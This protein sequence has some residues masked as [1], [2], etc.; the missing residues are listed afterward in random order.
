[1]KK[2]ALDA[3]MIRH[4]GIGTYVRGLLSGMDQTGLPAEMKI[5]LRCPENPGYARFDWS[6]FQS[7]IYSVQEQLA[8]TS[9]AG[10][11][12]LWH[13]PHYNI[14][15][16]LS[17]PKL[18]VTVHDL[19]HWIFRG[20]F[21]SRMQAYY[22]EIMMRRLVK[23]SARVIA[24]SQKT[25]QDLIDFFQAPADKITVI[26]EGVDPAF[27]P[28]ETPVLL[29]EIRVKHR[30]PEKF[31]LYVGLLKPHK[32]VLW[33]ARLFRRLHCEKKISA[34]LV[35]VGKKDRA[36]RPGFEE[37]GALSREDAV[38]YLEQTTGD[39]LKKL[40]QGAL[41]LVH[42]SLYEGFGLTL[43]ESMAS[44]TPVIA[45]NTASIPE[46]AGDAGILLRPND[47]DAMTRTL[48]E[49]EQ[50][51]TLRAQYRAKGL[52]QVKKF[53]WKKT[54]EETLRVYREVLQ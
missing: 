21:F 15:Y 12:D 7:P 24:V 26:Y 19:I 35:I 10:D 38:I 33:L 50:S 46:V 39:D 44:G 9:Q 13:S 5:S 32:N 37:L 45:F 52:A 22:T 4:S 30:L 49:M 2:I 6:P 3:R 27:K 8:F 40:Y 31:F 1:M 43:L 16:F 53:D 41:A 47:E 42:P 20:R 34:P 23:T 28:C 11:C 17:G 14:P 29:K 18:V 51:E 25:K 36:Y 48:I 54:A